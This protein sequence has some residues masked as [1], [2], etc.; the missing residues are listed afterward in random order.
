[1]VNAIT[2][3]VRYS[4]MEPKK[5]GLSQLCE[6]CPEVVITDERVTIGEDTNTVRLPH[7]EW[8]ELVSLIKRGEV[9]EILPRWDAAPSR[10][11]RQWG[12]TLFG[13]CATGRLRKY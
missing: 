6:A 2:A 5:F 13:G 12:R 8:N 11:A 10:A 1:M 3:M 9:G 7:A 4:L